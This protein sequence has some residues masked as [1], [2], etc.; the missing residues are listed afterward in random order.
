MEDP[1]VGP[2][3][4]DLSVA[5]ALLEAPPLV[6]PS[7]V[8]VPSEVQPLL[9]AFLG[10]Q[11][12]V[13]PLWEA[14]AKLADPALTAA[15]QRQGDPASQAELVTP[16]WPVYRASCYRH[17]SSRHQGS[18]KTATREV[19]MAVPRPE[20]GATQMSVLPRTPRNSSE[21]LQLRSRPSSA[22]QERTQTRWLQ[23]C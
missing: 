20:R 1:L 10:A 18:P 13:V 9:V 11:L 15:R 12:S 6:A 2:P 23:W 8:R 22:R 19:R 17:H 4:G 16:G 14:R 5:E 3:S 7:E 21:G